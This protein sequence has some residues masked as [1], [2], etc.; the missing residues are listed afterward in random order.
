[1]V[2]DLSLMTV[3]MS[4]GVAFPL[5][6]VASIA[7]AMVFN[8]FLNRWM[9][10]LGATRSTWRPQLAKFVA[11]CSVGLTINWSVSNALYSLL[12][13]WRWAYQLFCMAGILAGLGSNYL[14]SKCV[15]FGIEPS[16]DKPPTSRT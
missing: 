1:M 12:P 6:R 15:V 9:T 8:F 13:S 14:F 16:R 2:V 10:F 11:A 7:A 3:L 4:L 5:A